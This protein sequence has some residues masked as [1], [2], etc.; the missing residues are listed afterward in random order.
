M[1]I[2]GAIAV[3]KQ[4]AYVERMGS[5][6]LI[7]AG[8]SG[9]LTVGATLALCHVFGERRS[10]ALLGGLLV[11][12]LLSLWCLFDF[13]YYGLDV[14]GPPPGMLLIGGLIMVPLV[15]VCSILVSIVTA[16][17]YKKRCT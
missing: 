15:T 13:L 11:P 6:I 4:W 10:A 9:L 14:D 5:E 17:I 2:L 16:R 7:F 8:L 3:I 12:V 1:S